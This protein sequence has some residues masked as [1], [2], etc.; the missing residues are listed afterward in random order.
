[1]GYYNLGMILRRSNRLPEA[2]QAYSKAIQLAPNYAE[3]YQNLGVALLKFG[4]Y[5]DGVKALQNASQLLSARGNVAE[6]QKIQEYLRSI[7]VN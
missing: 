2:I 3:A 4:N 1:M 7:G 5:N 6:S